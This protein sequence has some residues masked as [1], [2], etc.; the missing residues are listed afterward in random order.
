MVVRRGEYKCICE[1]KVG[2]DG[3]GDTSVSVDT[4]WGRGGRGLLRGVGGT[5]V[6]VN[7]RWGTGGRGL[8]GL[9]M[10]M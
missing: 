7:K 4:T 8:G 1:Y 10:Y 5:C 3:G 6:H 9:Q 2:G